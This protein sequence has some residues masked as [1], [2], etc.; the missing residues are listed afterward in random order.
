M[1]KF[2]KFDDNSDLFLINTNKLNFVGMSNIDITF[3]FDGE[4]M[5]VTKDYND[6]EKMKK[7]LNFFHSKCNS[8]IIK[9]ENN[10]NFL[11]INIDLLLTVNADFENKELVF[12]FEEKNIFSK[13]YESTTEMIS[14]LNSFN[15]LMISK[16]I[17]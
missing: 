7:A 9:F 6:K 16:K 3:N 13:T 17:I 1:S 12:I 8:N 15:N 11:L 2:V 10:E 14:A 4:K 5:F